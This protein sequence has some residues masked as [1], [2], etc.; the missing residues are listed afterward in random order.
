MVLHDMHMHLAMLEEGQSEQEKKQ[1]ELEIISLI[2]KTG[3]V[4]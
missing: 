3:T 2:N 1:R 4:I